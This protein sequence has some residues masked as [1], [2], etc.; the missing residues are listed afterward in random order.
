MAVLAAFVATSC[1]DDKE[2]DEKSS[3]PNV[4]DCVNMEYDEDGNPK[5]MDLM[6]KCEEMAEEVK[7]DDEKMKELM[8]EAKKC[9]K[10]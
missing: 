3:G 4:C 10:E 6:E 1:G 2:S 7:G 5:D 9:E 8:E